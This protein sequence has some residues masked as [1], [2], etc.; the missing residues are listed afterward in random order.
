MKQPSL[1]KWT[2]RTEPVVVEC[3][4]NKRTENNNKRSS[5]ERRH[6]SINL[7]DRRRQETSAAPTPSLCSM[8]DDNF[9][10]DQF[11][12]F[13]QTTNV[14]APST[15]T[16]S[17]S[18]TTGNKRRHKRCDIDNDNDGWQEYVPGFDIDAGQNWFYPVNYPK[19]TYQ[20]SIVETALYNNT[21]V[22]LP[23]GLGKTFIAAVVIYNFYRYFV[24]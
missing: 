16:A 12:E 22:A 10:D 19:R 13:I 15:S 6:S 3:D 9:D 2:K 18:T 21:L 11:V 7:D 17:S 20:Y 24:T 1:L 5:N 8:F 23:T 14:D 4:D